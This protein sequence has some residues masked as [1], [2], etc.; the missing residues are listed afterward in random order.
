MDTVH[1]RVIRSSQ[2]EYSRFPNLWSD[3]GRSRASHSEEYWARITQGPISVQNR[4]SPKSSPTGRID[5]VGP[6]EVVATTW[7]PHRRPTFEP[8]GPHRLS[9]PDP[10]NDGSSCPA[11]RARRPAVGRRPPT[12]T[13]ATVWHPSGI[14]RVRLRITVIPD[15]SRVPGAQVPQRQPGRVELR[16][17]RLFPSFQRNQMR[18]RGR[19]PPP[20]FVGVREPQPTSTAVRTVLRP[21]HQGDQPQKPFAIIH[22]WNGSHIADGPH[23][24]SNIINV[25]HHDDRTEIGEDA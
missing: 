10:A 23:R 13:R 18:H 9:R 17:D 16:R 5:P 2:M 20:L 6:P 19:V 24:N 4:S 3:S 7:P 11:W 12:R 15:R 8:V 1:E 25:V 21:G 22:T 14:R